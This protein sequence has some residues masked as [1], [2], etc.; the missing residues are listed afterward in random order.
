MI[1]NQMEEGITEKV[2]ENEIPEKEKEF[3]LQRNYILKDEFDTFD[4]FLQSYSKILEGFLNFI[5][6]A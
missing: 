4:Q 1:Q 3:Y 2:K 5:F 6:F